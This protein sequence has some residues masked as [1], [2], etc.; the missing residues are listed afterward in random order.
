M[1][2][3]TTPIAIES[4]IADHVA[5]SFKQE[6]ASSE[7]GGTAAKIR[8]RITNR[9]QPFEVSPEQDNAPP[10]V[11]ALYG[12]LFRA[13]TLAPPAAGSPHDR[14]PQ[15]KRLH[16]KL[17]ALHGASKSSADR[18][19]AAP[20]VNLLLERQGLAMKNEYTVGFGRLEICLVA[21]A[22]FIPVL[23]DSIDFVWAL[24]V[25]ALSIGRSWHLDRQC[26][27]RSARIAEIDA[28]V[29][30]GGLLPQS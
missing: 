26:K 23:L 5:L 2:A 28:A 29:A 13:F 24:P 19:A 9:F 8:S 22:A 27:K 11:Q 18:G 7:A 3:E 4:M 6:E 14:L 25:L 21:I 10:A 15:L 16:D 17:E 30:S 12:R 1:S 20:Q